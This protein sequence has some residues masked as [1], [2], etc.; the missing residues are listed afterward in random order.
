MWRRVSLHKCIPKWVRI[1]PSHTWCLSKCLK[2]DSSALRSWWEGHVVSEWPITYVYSTTRSNFHIN[3]ILN[4]TYICFISLCRS[5]SMSITCQNPHT[6]SAF[7]SSLLCA[8]AAASVCRVWDLYW[9]RYNIGRI[10]Y[11]VRSP[12][13]GLT[14]SMTKPLQRCCL[15]SELRSVALQITNP[16]GLL[17]F[18]NRFRISCIFLILRIN[19]WIYVQRKTDPNHS[20]ASVNPFKLKPQS[21][22]H[23]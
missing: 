11:C 23:P 19:L 3:L 12:S 1:Y 10:I 5:I 8:C 18:D 15:L 17:V 21:W 20:D 22:Q 9:S 7:D 4:L 6:L 14:K 16:N 13:L 2:V